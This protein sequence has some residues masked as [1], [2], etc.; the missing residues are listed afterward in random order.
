MVAAPDSPTGF[1]YVLPDGGRLVGAPPANKPPQIKLG[2][3][4]VGD[5][6]NGNPQFKV[7]PLEKDAVIVKPPK[8]NGEKVNSKL[9]AGGN[10]LNSDPRAAAIKNQLKSG[11]ITKEQARERIAKLGYKP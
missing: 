6:A 11:L 1:S 10:S 9:G 5:D 4:Y 7:V 3:T 8:G 2:Q